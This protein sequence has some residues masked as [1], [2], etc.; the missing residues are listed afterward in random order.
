MS[1]SNLASALRFRRRAARPIHGD[2]ASLDDRTLVDI[3][4]IRAELRSPR[5]GRR[6]GRLY[7]LDSSTQV[8]DA[9]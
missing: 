4:L 2:P 9:T 3:G 7:F 1:M 5:H 8:R 6:L